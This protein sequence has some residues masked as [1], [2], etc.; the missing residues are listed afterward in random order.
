MAKYI[1]LFYLEC[2]IRF[3]CDTNK[4]KILPKNEAKKLKPSKLLLS[5]IAIKQHH[6]PLP[7]IQITHGMR[8]VQKKKLTYLPE[9]RMLT[10]ILSI[11]GK[12]RAEVNR[13]RSTKIERD[14]YTYMKK[15]TYT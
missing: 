5:T 2:W 7:R 8:K 13:K 10:E 15:K 9:N 11:G 12:K 6:P 14:Q 3:T 4:K 1:Y